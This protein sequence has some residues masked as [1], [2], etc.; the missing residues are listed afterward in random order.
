MENPIKMDD[1]GVPPIQETSKSPMFSEKM[2]K[3]IFPPWK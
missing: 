3:V 2:W 1:S